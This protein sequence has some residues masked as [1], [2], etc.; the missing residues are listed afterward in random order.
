[1]TKLTL[2]PAV[3]IGLIYTYHAAAQS[4]STGEN[5]KP[6]Q[7]MHPDQEGAKRWPNRTCRTSLAEQ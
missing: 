6:S 3:F 5:S 1:M 7:D 2:V 4:K